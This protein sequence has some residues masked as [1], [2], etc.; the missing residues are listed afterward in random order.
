MDALNYEQLYGWTVWLNMEPRGE[1][2][3]DHRSGL[4]TAFVRQASG[5]V[6]GKEDPNDFVLKFEAQGHVEPEVAEVI[7][8]LF[9]A[10]TAFLS[11]FD[12]S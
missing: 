6:E 9:A 2:R 8:E 1:K 3:A 5:F 10:P 11:F 4:L 7:D 12:V